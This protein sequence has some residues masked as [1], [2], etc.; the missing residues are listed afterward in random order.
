MI[1]HC[2]LYDLP[3]ANILSFFTAIA[4]IAIAFIAKYELDKNSEI[5]SAEIINDFTS[6]FFTPKTSELIFLFEYDQIKLVPD[7]KGE[8]KLK[9]LPEDYTFF[10]VTQSGYRRK[11]E[12]PA[13][14]L[15]NTNIYSPYEIEDNLL[16]YFEDMD[17]FLKKGVLKEDFVFEVFGFYII[18]IGKNQQIQDY[19]CQIREHYKD[20]L[21]YDKFEELIKKTPGNG[22]FVG[23]KHSKL[24]D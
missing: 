17:L 23:F 14:L 13:H 12:V 11:D 9:D 16:G 3:W 24:K 1:L 7:N 22:G 2:C 4:T 8:L 21:F 10:K 15:D 5:K 19:I 6:S 20:E 18:T